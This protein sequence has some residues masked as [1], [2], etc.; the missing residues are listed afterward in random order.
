MRPTTFA[1]AA[2]LASALTTSVSATFNAAASTNVVMY[3]G[4][5]SYQIPLLEV[6]QNP[7]VDVVV[8]GFINEFPTKVGGYPGSNFANACGDETFTAP[9]GTITHLKSNCPTIGPAITACQTTYGKKVILSLGGAYPTN[10]TLP[11][12]AISNYFAEFLWGAFGP[13][14]SP[15]ASWVA[16]G[17]PRPFGSAVVDGFDFDI[18]S[19]MASPPFSDYKSRGYADMIN[20]FKNDLYPTA[21]GTYY[22]SGAPQCITP[23][24]HLDD[25]MLNAPFDFLY[26]QFYNTPSCSARA[27]Y[28]GLSTFTFDSWVS[29]VTTLSANKNAKVYLGLVSTFHSPCTNQALTQH[30][31]QLEQM[32]PHTIPLLISTLRR[33]TL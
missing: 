24:S 19:N 18:E 3:W 16:A 13:I 33:P 11:T 12:T 17:S 14:T 8:L 28:N 29:R 7:S 32:V 15:P 31:S 1:R 25:A 6:C 2:A 10:Y 27:A 20:H 23:D 30:D 5:G 9:D 26:V 22:I 21:A 4:Q